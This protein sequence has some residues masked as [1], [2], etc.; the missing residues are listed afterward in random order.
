MGE[1]AQVIEDLFEIRGELDVLLSVYWRTLDREPRLR[2][3]ISEAAEVAQTKYRDRLAE[4]NDE[5]VR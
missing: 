5:V 4:I 1:E 2:N 3:L